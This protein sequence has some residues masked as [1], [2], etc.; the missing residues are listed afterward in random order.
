M[1]TAGTLACGLI[2]P[3]CGRDS[4]QAVRAPSV[5]SETTLR[6]T[7]D[8]DP[9]FGERATPV[10]ASIQA[11]LRFREPDADG[12]DGTVWAAR[13][14]RALEEL[15]GP[16]LLGGAPPEGALAPGFVGVD[17]LS[18]ELAQRPGPL[19][20]RV[21]VEAGDGPGPDLA[22]LTPAEG[23]F[24]ALDEVAVEVLRSELT[25]PAG[26]ETD[27][28]IEVSGRHAGRRAQYAGLWSA[29]WI[30]DGERPR[31]VELRRSD[32]RWALADGPLFADVTGVV[33]A[34]N[35]CFDDEYRRDPESYFFHSDRLTQY[36]LLGN[37]GFAVGDIDGDGWDDVYACTAAGIAN[38]LFLGRPDGTTREATGAWK[39]GFLDQSRSALILDLDGDGHRDL[40]VATGPDVVI[41]WNDG[42]SC[43]ERTR[44]S[45]GGHEEAYSLA[46]CDVDQDGDVDLFVCRYGSEGAMQGT[47]TP[48][49][50]AFNGAPNV[51]WRNEGE[52]RFVDVT[53]EVG[54]D[55]QNSKFSF[56]CVWDDFDD[57]G[58]FDLYITNDF[59][60]NHY[61]R[62]DDGHFSDVATPIGAEDMAAGMGPTCA[63]FDGDGALDL[64]VSNIYAAEGLR[65]TADERFLH[66]LPAELLPRYQRHARGNTLL[67][68]RGDG[69]FEDVSVERR[70]NRGGWAWGAR[71]G[72]FDSDGW[73]DI[74]VPNG[75][76]TSDHAYEADEF[77]WRFVISR[78]PVDDKPSMEYEDAWLTIQYLAFD[79]GAGW[80]GG[81]RDVL[82]ANRGGRDFVDA[83][84]LA[85]PGGP[86]DGRSAA[87]LDW[88]RDGR[89]DL[90]LKNRDG[91]RLQLLLNRL[92][93][94]ERSWVVLEL[95]DR[96]PNRDAVGA[97]VRVEAGGRTF[98]RTVY[99]GDGYLCQNTLRQHV[100]L[101]AAQRVDLV[102]VRWADGQ[103]QRFDGGLEANRAWRLVRGEAQPRPL[104]WQAVAELARAEAPVEPIPGPMDRIVLCDK[105]PA[106]FAPLPSFERSDRRVADV[107][108]AKGGPLLVAFWRHGD[109]TGLEQIRRF[110]RGRDALDASGLT[111]VPLTVDEG[112][113]LARARRVLDELGL[114]REAGFADGKTLQA[115]EVLLAEVFHRTDNTPLPSSLLFDR[116]GQLCVV[117]HGPVAVARLLSD[118]ATLRTMKPARGNC[119][120]LA[121][122]I[123]VDRP[124]RD[125]A[126][127]AEVL[128]Q[129]GYAEQAAFYRQLRARR[130]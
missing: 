42:T 6:A 38:R 87:T 104:A 1:F 21:E 101:G 112:P 113:D 100:G 71:F 120:A 29:A 12:W 28:R 4:E 89:L 20:L 117:Y 60:R 13:A 35:A 7:Q 45:S 124:R 103:V 50:D 14:G 84:A 90:L 33:F 108:G 31:L 8:L 70:A 129:L 41:C 57:D 34:A 19:E 130:R 80:N 63:D 39:V 55:D 49:H 119:A 86:S 23:P 77:F 125:F 59:G 98:L 48:Y 127:L 9:L 118:V 43:S 18:G 114:T 3:G 105:L 67:R 69:T 82:L 99:A 107:A 123:W 36:D 46:A 62:N 56:G 116:R 47:P 73:L 83:G 88:D 66:H 17:R 44:L 65:A 78:S 22:R 26:L 126:A 61:Y 75:L 121:D 52:R 10:R 109:E 54:L 2:A 76:F 25:A 97:R 64:Y 11:N 128:H 79:Q 85:R 102:E 110:A 53:A 106:P 81:E 58:D 15:L 115:Y 16:V 5:S 96:A 111:V 95:E 91:P 30:R 24:E 40:V 92:P 94:D 51:Y 74:Y 27:V 122:G 68:N 72:D 37:Q 32:S 93:L